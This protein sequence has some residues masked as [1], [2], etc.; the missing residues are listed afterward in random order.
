[1]ADVNKFTQ[2]DVD[3]IDKFLSLACYNSWEEDI[4]DILSALQPALNMTDTYDSVK[5]PDWKR[6]CGRDKVEEFGGIFWSWLVLQYG[7]YG[8]SPRYG[9]IYAENAR[10]IYNIIQKI[11]ETEGEYRISMDE[12]MNASDIIEGIVDILAM[13]EMSIETENNVIEAA[14]D[15]KK[16]KITVEE[17]EE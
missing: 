7:D 1:M 16:F 15:G 14:L 13:S 10:R 12:V 4:Q 6:K 17:V 5:R 11:Y 9:W 3:S 8:T 2:A